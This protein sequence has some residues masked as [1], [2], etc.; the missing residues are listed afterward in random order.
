M[1]PFMD[2]GMG[3][4]LDIAGLGDGT[5]LIYRTTFGTMPNVRVADTLVSRVD[6][7]DLHKMH[8]IEPL[9][10]VG[11]DSALCERISSR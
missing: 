9:R 3:S 10:I 5:T 1:D 11:D 4:I 6:I 8:D 7:E 2:S